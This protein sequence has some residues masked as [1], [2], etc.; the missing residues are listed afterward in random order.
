MKKISVLSLGITFCLNAMAQNSKV[1]SA[2]MHLDTYA[3]QRD[4]TELMAAK[5]SIDEAA[6]NDKT[7]DEPKMYLYRGE[8]YNVTFKIRLDNMVTK[9]VAA[10]TKDMNKATSQ[11]YTNL[12]TNTICVAA[13]SFVKVLQLAPTDYYADEAKEKQNLPTCIV[14]LENKALRDY[15]AAKYSTSLALYKKLISIFLL[16]NPKDTSKTFKENIEMAAYSADNGGDNTTAFTYY[17]Q[18]IGLKYD[19]ATPY[20][21]LSAMYL[22]QKDSA[23]AWDYIE[24]GRAQYPDDLNLIITETNFYITRHDYGKAEGNLM[25]TIS[26]VQQR[27]DKNKNKALLASL[28][29][30]LGGIY[31]KKANPKD[32]QGADLPRPADYDS[33]FSKADSNYSRALAIAPDNFDVLFAIGA[34]NFNRAVP[35]T[36]QANDLPLNAKDKY[37][38]LMDQAKVYFL[39]AQPYFERAYKINPNDAS[40]SN[41]LKEV[42]ASTGQTDKADAMNKK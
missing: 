11:A 16:L 1:T 13:N 24:K 30:N 8:V 15:D 3:N 20:R 28:Y 19:G 18:V 34:L 42:Y 29:T 41:A 9:L 35:I 10:G 7:K 22:K 21:S 33:L 27:P 14:F 39:Q 17:Q 5:E 31:D 4:T 2:K 6:I 12:D 23:K 26:K 25:L 32:A 40:N 36:K 38:K 37:D